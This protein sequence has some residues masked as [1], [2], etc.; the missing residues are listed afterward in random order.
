MVWRLWNSRIHGRK[1][2]EMKA[3][4]AAPIPGRDNIE[5]VKKKTE[6]HQNEYGM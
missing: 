4:Y 5:N 1:F 2:M 3:L 6:T